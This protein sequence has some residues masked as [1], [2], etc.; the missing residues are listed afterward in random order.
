[1]VVDSLAAIPD[2]TKM[3]GLIRGVVPNLIAGVGVSLLQYADDII[4]MVQGSDMDIANLKFPLLCFQQMSGHT[5]NFAKSELMILGYSDEEQQSITDRLNCP[6][7]SFPTSYLGIP[8]SDA[9]LSGVGSTAGGDQDPTPSRAL[10]GLVA[11]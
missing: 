5:I 10:A 4:I 7:G 11:I 9:R 2:K 1:M 6:L 8:I 3:A